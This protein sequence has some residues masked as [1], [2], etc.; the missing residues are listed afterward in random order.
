MPVGDPAIDPDAARRYREDP[1]DVLLM[2]PRSESDLQAEA[3]L[4]YAVGLSG[5][6]CGLVVITEPVGA[7]LGAPGHGG[8]AIVRLGEVLA[9]AGDGDDVL[10][11]DIDLPVPRPEPTQAF[12]GLPTILEQRLAVHRGLRHEPGYPA[13][14]T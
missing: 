3:V 2:S 6:L 5:S 7:P 9:E 11:E 10:L 13:E 1:P 8:S 12:P 14:L 4:E